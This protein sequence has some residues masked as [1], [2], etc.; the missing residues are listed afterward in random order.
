MYMKLTDY[1]KNPLIAN[2]S[3]IAM[4]NDTFRAAIWTGSYAQVT[5]MCISPY[6]EIG[7]E[8]HGD[9]DQILFVVDGYASVEMGKCRCQMDWKKKACKGDMIIVPAGTWHNVKNCGRTAL[10][11]A[12]V[13]A[14]PKHPKGTVQLTKEDED[15]DSTDWAK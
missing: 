6:E 9:T 4:E 14:P 13:Y 10:K 2:L 8:Y 1:G 11:L 5:V 15:R 3:Q 12:S 7:T